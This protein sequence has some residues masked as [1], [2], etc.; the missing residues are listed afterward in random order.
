MFLDLQEV[1]YHL[2]EKPITYSG[3][4]IVN[5]ARMYGNAV[6]KREKAGC[7]KW[8]VKAPFKGQEY[9]DKMMGCKARAA[10]KGYMA[11]AKYAQNLS[12]NCKN[13]K[14]KQLVTQYLNDLKDAIEEEKSYL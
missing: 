11:S 8:S 4:K 1:L 5:L 10:I 2:Q 14:C 6:E 3:T 13:D 9:R 7:E 12:K